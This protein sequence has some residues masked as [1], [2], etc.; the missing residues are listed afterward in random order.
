MMNKP[1]LI[2]ADELKRYIDDC[3]ICYRCPDKKVRCSYDCD[4]PDFLTSKME[5]VINEQPT[6]YDIAKV[7]ERLE[8]FLK[9]DNV[10]YITVN[11]AIEIVRKGGGKH[12]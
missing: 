11:E 10:H 6:A 9:S 7:V 2:D 5:F 8:K 12:D 1:R 3:D 4:F